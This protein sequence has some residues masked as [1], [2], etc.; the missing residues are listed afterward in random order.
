MN[1]IW[2]TEAEISMCLLWTPFAGTTETGD[3]SVCAQK[4]PLRCHS[5]IRECLLHANI[6]K[7]NN[8]IAI[9]LRR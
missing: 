5:C 6:Y 4:V 8:L 2:T 9:L 3:T 7:M 1:T